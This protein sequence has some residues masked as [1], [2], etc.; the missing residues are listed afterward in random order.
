MEEEEGSTAWAKEGADV[1]E[2]DY[3][4]NGVMQILVED[5]ER[6]IGKKVRNKAA[7]FM[8][9]HINLMKTLMKKGCVL[10]EKTFF[11]KHVTRERCR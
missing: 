6:W 5:W 4:V 9:V 1:C 10:K 11:L 2:D 8:G 7:N 3:L